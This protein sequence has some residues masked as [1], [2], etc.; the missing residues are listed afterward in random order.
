MIQGEGLMTDSQFTVG[1]YTVAKVS[2][3]APWRWIGDGMRDL[4]RAP[5]PSLALGLVF[6]LIGAAAT[7]GLW[8]LD[9][10]AWIPVAL[11][12]FA[13]VGPI[14]AIGFYNISKRL[15]RSEK[16]RLADAFHV[17]AASPTQLAYIG[18][19][20]MSA[21]LIWTRIAQVIFA[22]FMLGDYPPLSE[23]MAFALTNPEG[24]LL[25][26]IGSAVGGVIGFAIFAIS[27]LSIPL[28]MDRDAD[29]ATAIIISVN[30]VRKNFATM[31]LWAWLIAV[32]TA[33]GAAFAMVGLIFTF[34]L[35]GHA[36]W[37]AY[38]DIVRR[39]LDPEDAEA[40][41]MPLRS[42]A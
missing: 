32:I 9:M 25:L 12:G 23:F 1:K 2:L 33:L 31:L 8:R 28:L 17:Q 38:R 15:D 4:T 10:S 35:L 21:F 26:G 19:V 5:G 41:A 13:L 6:F 14:L 42:V 30:A 3:D 27:A 11:G 36:T 16:I 34:P 20:L 29:F 37:R 24:M 18:F 7:A 40:D 22:F 39:P